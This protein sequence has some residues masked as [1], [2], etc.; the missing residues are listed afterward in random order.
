MS[1]AER[2]PVVDMS[3]GA[4]SDDD[5]QSDV[6]VENASPPASPVPASPAPS[7]ASRASSGRSRP[8]SRGSTGS[9]DYDDDGDDGEERLHGHAHHARYHPHHHHYPLHHHHHQHHHSGRVNGHPDPLPNNNNNNDSRLADKNARLAAPSADGRSSSPRAHTDSSPAAKLSFGIS[10]ILS[11]SPGPRGGGPGSRGEGLPYGLPPPPPGLVAGFSPPPAHLGPG[12][13]PRPPP[14]A[15]LVAPRPYSP[16]AD[17]CLGPAGVIKVPAHRPMPLAHLGFS[18]LMFPWMQ[19]RK[20]RLT[21]KKYAAPC[22][23]MSRIS[24]PC[25][26]VCGAYI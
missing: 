3:G 11:S 17:G 5:D 23:L 15:H 18:P 12:L 21:G 14:P 20:D 6:D 25:T 22:T 19:D 9:A 1:D 8:D 16:G 10:R 7:S 26:A 13:P 4:L 24:Y 2:H